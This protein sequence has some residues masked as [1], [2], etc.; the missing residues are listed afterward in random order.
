MIILKS[1]RKEPIAH[2]VEVDIQTDQT[3]GYQKQN[4][5]V[6]EASITLHVNLDLR[7]NEVSRMDYDYSMTVRCN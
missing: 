6:F 1:K 7:I 4:V 2:F 5:F 3:Y